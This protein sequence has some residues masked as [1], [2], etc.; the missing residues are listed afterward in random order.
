V[1]GRS[2]PKAEAVTEAVAKS[3]QTWINTEEFIEDK[4]PVDI[5]YNLQIDCEVFQ[6]G[7][8]ES[9]L[10]DMLLRAI[11]LKALK[12]LTFRITEIDVPKPF[13]IYWK[14]LNRG[15]L[16]RQRNMVRGQIVPDSGAERRDET[17]NFAG[18]HIVECYAVKNGVVVAKDRIDVPI[19]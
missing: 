8:R 12:K 11:R 15:G 13:T 14:V 7:F 16:A 17:T 5:R 4:F 9:T 10:R 18:E 19:Q 1:F 3:A 2:F 6:N